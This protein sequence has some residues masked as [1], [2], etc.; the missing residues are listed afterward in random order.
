MTGAL[1]RIGRGCAKH[2][3]PVIAIWV[4]LTVALAVAGRIVGDANNDNLSLPGTGSTEAQDLLQD[5]LPAQAN[6]TNPIVMQAHKGKLTDSANSKAVK[7]TVDSLKQQPEVRSAISPLSD[8]GSYALS[9][10]KTIGYVIVTLYDGP[11]DLSESDAEDVFDAA[12]PASDAGLKVAA[13]GYL[14]QAL[15]ETDTESSEAIGIAAAIVILLFAFGTVTAMALP[16]VTAVLGLVS[17][18]AILKLLSH[19]VDIPTVAPTLATMIGLGVGIDYALFLVTRHKQQLREGM[20]MGESIAR[21]TATAGGAVVFAG[22]TVIVALVS[23]LAAGIPLV[24]AMGCSAAVAVVVSVL[25]ATTLLPALLGALGPR[26]DSLKVKLGRTHPD[27]HEPH[28]WRRWAEGVANRPWRSLLASSFVLLFIAIPTLNLE[29]GASDN[30][31]LPKDTTA[32]QAYDLI[33]EG[34]GPGWN[35]PLLIGVEL[36]SPAKP[37]QSDVNKAKSQQQQLAQQQ[38]EQ[39]QQLEAEGVPPDQA[40]QQVQQQT[41]SQQQ[42]LD[43]QTKAAESPANDPRLTNLEDAIKKTPGIDS[44]SPATV[45]KAGTVAVFTAIATTAPSDPKTGDLVENLRDNVVPKAIKGT[46]LTVFAGGQTAGYI[47][48]A[49][50]IADKLPQ[51]I[52]LVVI[53]SFFL[54]L[55]AFRSVLLPIK[56]AVANLLSVGAAYGVVTFVFQEGHGATLI[57]LDGAVPI[58]SYVPLLMFTILFGLSM[59]Y[60]VFLLSQI[61]EHYLEDG[62]TRKAIVDGLAN[63]GRVITSAALIMVCVFSSFV[64][65]GDAVVKQFGVGLAVAIA[66]DATLV[67]CLFVPAAM[68]LMGDKCWWIPKWLDKILPHVNIEGGDF[69]EKRAARAAKAESVASS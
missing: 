35:G 7:Q 21:S 25:A 17:T 31:E 14:G 65:S 47:D 37:D 50:R 18:L 10:D 4:V 24:G 12:S 56:A 39:E 68:T 2:H 41:S 54:L 69:F 1:Y 66:I 16:I 61:Q 42:K 28:G 30:G 67:R 40:Q 59:D 46:D 20:E 29:L 55:L 23:L 62:D 57:G 33:S 13:G 48:L 19:L 43:Q 8:A 32:R 22:G 64:L 53:L 34:F 9:K 63:T 36:G 26:I 27:D 58:A 3:W 52:A 49:A 5:N 51:M 44:V 11:S 45:D 6:G 38:Q 15:S 60:E